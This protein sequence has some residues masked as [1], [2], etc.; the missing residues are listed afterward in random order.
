MKSKRV[1]AAAS[2]Q[3]LASL[4][5]PNYKR[6]ISKR[7]RNIFLVL[8]INGWFRVLSSVSGKKVRFIE[9]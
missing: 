9:Y 8:E 5:T 1:I 3:D 6:F 7:I 2:K 4:Y